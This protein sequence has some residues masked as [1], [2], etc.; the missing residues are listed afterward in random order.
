M[1]L[2][3]EKLFNASVIRGYRQLN[4][5]YLLGLAKKTG[6][7]LATLDAG[8]SLSAVIGASRS[9]LAVISTGDSDK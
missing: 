8:I 6:G 4:D 1:S 5:I 9:N 2:T 7:Y 3:N